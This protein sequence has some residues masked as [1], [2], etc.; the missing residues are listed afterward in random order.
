MLKSPCYTIKLTSDSSEDL[1]GTNLD[2][3][4]NDDTYTVVPYSWCT[5]AGDVDPADLAGDGATYFHPMMQV[6]TSNNYARNYNT[7]N[8]DELTNAKQAH[9]ASGDRKNFDAA[10][11]LAI[12]TP[13]MIARATA[14][15]DLWF[16]DWQLAAVNAEL[17]DYVG[18]ENAKI[19]N[20]GTA[21][22]IGK[23]ETT[24]TT[25]TTAWETAQKNEAAAKAWQATAQ[26]E[27]ERAEADR[28]EA[29]ALLVD[30]VADIAPLA[31]AEAAA[32]EE[33]DTAV[34]EQAARDEAT[35]ALGVPYKAKDPDDAESEE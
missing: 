30:L 8:T 7:V 34:E 33:Y 5:S 24:Q 13:N 31:R 21:T 35:A 28:K 29:T 17:T 27:A 16:S 12:T 15:I 10:G 6:A 9:S 23:A 14:Q 25:K 4:A 3:V 20:W 1:S 22:E 18:D 11:G 2:T 19:D 26:A 32:Q